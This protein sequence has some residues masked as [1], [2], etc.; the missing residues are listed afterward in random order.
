[1]SRIKDK[2][3]RLH[4]EANHPAQSMQPRALHR[5]SDEEMIHQPI[6]QIHPEHHQQNQH[7]GLQHLV[8]NGA[9]ADFDHVNPV[10]VRGRQIVLVLNALVEIAEV[11]LVD[12]NL[13]QG[14]DRLGRAARSNCA[15]LPAVASIPLLACC[16]IA[17]LLETSMATWA[18]SASWLCL[19]LLP[20]CLASSNACCNCAL[21]AAQS[22]PGGELGDG[23]KMNRLE[24]CCWHC[25]AGLGIVGLVLLLGRLMTVE[26]A[27]NSAE[28]VRPGADQVSLYVFQFVLVEFQLRLGQIDLLLQG[29][30]GALIF[31][32]CEL[33]L[34]L[35]DPGL[36]GSDGSVGLI[37]LGKQF[38][39]LG[40]R[41]E[42]D[43][44]WPGAFRS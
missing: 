29:V 12:G 6:A 37:G 10:A 7:R 1:M 34:Q 16:A 22:V 43:A 41:P 25:R 13:V 26:L 14:S 2:P 20:A 24:G 9:L 11:F 44:R 3:K 39:A 5:Q 21:L 38:L 36:V 18:C 40:R 4:R 27:L 33:L 15:S 30:A 23:R 8:R 19:S 42:P 35:V 32:A 28:A 31:R 17:S